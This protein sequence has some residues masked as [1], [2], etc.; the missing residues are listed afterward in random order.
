M[1]L[2]VTTMTTARRSLTEL[3]EL[4][5]ER[6]LLAVL[7]GPRESLGLITLSPPVLAALI[8]VQTI[9][10]VS[11]SPAPVRK[12]TRTDAAMV[13][14]FLDQILEELDL[15]I[16]ADADR[17]W[18]G[19]FRYASF[20]DDPRPLGLLLEDCAYRVITVELSL[21]LGAKEG[22]MLLI[23]PAEGRG[24]LPLNAPQAEESPAEQ[25]FT[26]ALTEQVMETGC[27]LQA[28]LERLSLPLATLMAWQPG[29]VVELPNA[30]LERIAF[31]GLDGK[32]VAEGRL[33]QHRGMR[34]V[35]LAGAVTESAPAPM[36]FGMSEDILSFPMTGTDD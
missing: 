1:V 36:S 27:T 23:L 32:P 2:D 24:E 30:T 21:G 26:Q 29:D 15:Q 22:T 10:K 25:M 4:P 7:E 31:V 14:A 11:T 8:E 34:A 28:M 9:G 12:P 3:L 19:G 16:E 6:S 35:R 20:L 33:G 17:V 18:A 13:S 5:E